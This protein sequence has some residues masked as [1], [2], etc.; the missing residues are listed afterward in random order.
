MN[1][2]TLLSNTNDKILKFL[3][4]FKNDNSFFVSSI[5]IHD[6]DEILFRGYNR[7]IGVP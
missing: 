4:E 6:N 5:F 3:E 1:K 2:I 7:R